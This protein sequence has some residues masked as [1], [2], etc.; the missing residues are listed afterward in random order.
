MDALTLTE[1]HWTQMWRHVSAR[2]PEEACGL[3]AGVGERVTAVYPVTN[4]LHSR[5]RFLMEAQ[6]QINAFIDIERRGW[7]ILAIY[8]S[9]P[10]GP[11]RPSPTDLAEFAYPGCIYLIWSYQP[12]AGPP[13]ICKAYTIEGQTVMEVEIK[14]S[15]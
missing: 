14:L 8:H 2:L 13:W 7:D 4:E 12:G 1:R 3:L 5:V 9:H 6:E 10:T 11:D 15:A